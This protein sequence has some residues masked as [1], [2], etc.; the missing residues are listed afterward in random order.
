MKIV[1]IG[2]TGL[3]G[4]KLVMTLRQQDHEVLAA[5]PESGVNTLTV[6]EGLAPALAGAQV[7]VDL[8]DSPSFFESVARVADSFSDGKTL[9]VA[10]APVQSISSEDVV[11]ALAELVLNRSCCTDR[12]LSHAQ[13]GGAGNL[14]SRSWSPR[15]PHRSSLARLSVVISYVPQ[16]DSHACR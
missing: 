5:S 14:L 7:V 12:F 2:G 15:C 6:V 4:S 1:V 11:A 3:I 13:R 10:S 8:E 16:S 9:R